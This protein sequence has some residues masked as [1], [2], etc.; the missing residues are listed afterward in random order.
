MFTQQRNNKRNK[1][2]SIALYNYLPKDNHY[3]S[4][5]NLTP[6][7][8]ITPFFK[9]KKEKRQPFIQQR[10]KDKR[11]LEQWWL[12]RIHHTRYPLEERMTLF[13]H[14]HFTSSMA[15]VQWPQ[16]MY[17]QNQL[18]RKHALNSF[19]DLL[20]TIYKDPAMLIYLNGQ[21]STKRKPN[22]NFARELLELFTL[23]QGHYSESDIIAAARAFTGWHYNMQQGKVIFRK[24]QHDNGIKHFMGQSGRFNGKDIINI[25]LDHPRTAEF[26]TEKFWHHF[27]SPEKPIKEYINFWAKLFRDSHYN[28]TV[29]IHTIIQSEPFWD[30]KNRGTIVKSPI[31]LTIG[32]LRELGLKQFNAY[33]RLFNLNRQM[34][35][36]L[37]NPPDV[38]GWQG[39]KNWLTSQSLVLRQEYLRKTSAEYEDMQYGNQMPKQLSATQLARMAINPPTG[40]HHP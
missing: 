32:L 39:G 18:L 11:A 6:W 34:G 29:L 19:A 31:E 12:E 37:F 2:A 7:Q 23:G 17:R 20:H 40:K 28:T 16:L 33:P 5:P 9:T 15:S 1:N 30:K 3:L 4:H 27:V 24:G 38:R 13:W 25:L 22:E 26:I 21:Q 35:Q 36:A 8:Q 10:N 14:N